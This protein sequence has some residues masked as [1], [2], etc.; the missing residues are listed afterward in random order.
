MPFV[1]T[2]IDLEIVILCGVSQTEK[3]KYFMK[4]LIWES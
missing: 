4:S 3:G 1:A 2:R